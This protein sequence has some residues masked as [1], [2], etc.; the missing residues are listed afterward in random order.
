MLRRQIA[1]SEFAGGLNEEQFTR[2]YEAITLFQLADSDHTGSL[3]RKQL[4]NWVRSHRGLIKKQLG[5][6]LDFNSFWQ[7]LMRFDAN[8]DGEVQLAEFVE[9][10]T[11]E[12]A[13]DEEFLRVMQQQDINSG[14]RARSGSSLD[15]KIQQGKAFIESSVSG[16]GA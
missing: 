12:E 13:P 7:D 8:H 5:S 11:Y 15:E 6:A 4:K 1:R 16:L 9:W 3:D 2:L 14:A 10:Y